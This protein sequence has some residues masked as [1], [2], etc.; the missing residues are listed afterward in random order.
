MQKHQPERFKEY[1]ET[2]DKSGFKIHGCDFV[3]KYEEDGGW[4]DEHGNYYDCNGL[5]VYEESDEEDDYNSYDG[6][7]WSD[8]ED[9]YDKL[10]GPNSKV[11]EDF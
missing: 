7:S 9:D 4:K 6:K 2:E 10:Y 11:I 5:P 8:Y 1:Y 3:F